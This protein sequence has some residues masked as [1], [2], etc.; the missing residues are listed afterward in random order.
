MKIY[1]NLW[2]DLLKETKTIIIVET[3][4][5]SLFYSFFIIV[6]TILVYGQIITMYYH[7]LNLWVVLIILSVIGIA[8]VQ[9][10]L[11]KKALVLKEKKLA[12]DVNKL[13]LY[14]FIINSIIIVIIGL[15]FV[16]IFIP[17]MQI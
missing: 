1:F 7:L 14:Q 6:P 13:F 4:F 5:A 15:L 8:Y 17:M 3:L 9:I 12:T 2:K 16:F 11:W 10:L